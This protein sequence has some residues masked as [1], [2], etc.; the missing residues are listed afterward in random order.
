ML[1]STFADRVNAVF[2]EYSRA[3]EP[4]EI[5]YHYTS[6]EAMV[7]IAETRI[8]R[9]SNVR[10]SNDP[11]ELTYGHGVIRAV[12]SDTFPDLDLKSIFEAIR[13][14]D[15]YAI[16]FSA[17][18]DSLPQWRAYCSNGRGVA[19]GFRSDVFEH[20][21]ELS[22]ARVEYARSAQCELIRKVLDI[23]APALRAVETGGRIPMPIFIDLAQIFVT[24]AVIVKDKAYATEREYR[25]FITQP[26]PT[27][28]N[29]QNVRFRVT[30]STV[31]PYLEF[32]AGQNDMPLGLR[33]IVIGPC[34]DAELTKPS[35]EAFAER[36]VQPP[37]HVRCSTVKM[38]A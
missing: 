35:I 16:S 27:R 37:P 24:L 19:L 2:T 30:P 23:Y 28:F 20:H 22:F 15:C 13:E 33:E 10:F 21:A 5:I 4:P 12:L 3:A 31:V 38:R 36:V 34:L 7:A 25:A 9:A 17:E 26:R 18:D 8:L 32:T 1:E 11:A 6:L 29:A 14:V